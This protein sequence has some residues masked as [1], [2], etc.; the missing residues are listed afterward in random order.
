MPTHGGCQGRRLH[1]SFET[2][3]AP[4]PLPGDPKNSDREPKRT[5]HQ[6][7]GRLLTRPCPLD[8]SQRLNA[9]LL[10]ATLLQTPKIVDVIHHAHKQ[11]IQHRGRIRDAIVQNPL[12]VTRL[13]FIGCNHGI[14]LL[15]V[16]HAPKDYPTLPPPSVSLAPMTGPRAKIPDLA[17]YR[18]P[19]ANSPPRAVRRR[20]L[21]HRPCAS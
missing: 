13:F 17:A 16:L 2:S 1:R 14:Y 21:L 8:R 7:I 15:T 4:H 20:L 18:R 11:H 5:S 6:L 12:A 19:C 3:Q 9:Y 10:S